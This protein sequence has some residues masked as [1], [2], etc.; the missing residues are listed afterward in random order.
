MGC[1]A[2]YRNG[3]VVGFCAKKAGLALPAIKGVSQS[4]RKVCRASDGEALKSILPEFMVFF[5]LEE[6]AYMAWRNIAVHGSL[7]KSEIRLFGLLGKLGNAVCGSGDLQFSESL[8]NGE[9]RLHVILKGAVIFAHITHRG[10]N[11]G[12][13]STLT[14]NGGALA[15][16]SSIFFGFLDGLNTHEADKRHE[17]PG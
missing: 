17:N 13:G 14:V 12:R 8:L 4:L 6:D 1:D 10:E 9:S 2:L 5:I 11:E 3:V 16:G 7:Q 15:G